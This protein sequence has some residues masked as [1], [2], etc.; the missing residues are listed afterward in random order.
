MT[1]RQEYIAAGELPRPNVYFVT[2]HSAITGQPHHLY[3]AAESARG[4][5]TRLRRICPDRYGFMPY[6]S[7]CVIKMRRFRVQDY[8]QSPQ[9]LVEALHLAQLLGERDTVNAL[10]RRPKD[11]EDALQASTSRVDTDAAWAALESE[12]AQLVDA[13]TKP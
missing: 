6:P 11:V 13:V 3:L 9:G 1:N 5:I 2:I 8:F 4:V 12:M 7:N 10:K